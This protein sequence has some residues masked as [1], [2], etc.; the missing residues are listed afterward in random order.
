MRLIILILVTFTVIPEVCRADTIHVPTDYLTIQEAITAAA[1]G[2][3]VLVAPGTYLENINFLGKAILVK[4]SDGA[5]VTTIDGNMTGSVVT[6]ASGEGPDSILE[7]FTITNGTGTLDPQGYYC[8]GG[9]F[10]ETSSPTVTKNTIT[11]NSTSQNYV[12]GAGIYCKQASPQIIENIVTENVLPYLCYGGGIY[13]VDH[14]SPLILENVISKNITSDWGNGGGIYCK[15][16]CDVIIRDNLI[17]DNILGYDTGHGGGI[18]VY[19]DCMAEITGN[20]IT[21]NE[22]EYGG[23]IHVSYA[24]YFIIENNRIIMNFASAQGCGG[25]IYCVD[26][27]G[28][29]SRNV[30][31]NNDAQ[32]SGAGMYI[33]TLIGTVSD[34]I[35][36]ENR[37]IDTW[38]EGGGIYAIF[39]KPTI[40][41][42]IIISNHSSR[43]GGIRCSKAWPEIINNTV[44]GNKAT[45][46]GGGLYMSMSNPLIITNSIFWKNN[47]PLGPEMYLSKPSLLEISYS[48]V[49]DGI[50]G[51]HVESGCI[52][53]WGSGMIS[54]DPLFVDLYKGDLHLTFPSPCNGTGDN[55]VIT[56]LY[57]M[58]GDPRIANSTVDMGADEFYTHLYCTGDVTP[59]GNIELKF[60][61]TPNTTPVILWLG[62]G[63]MDPPM[64]VKKYGDWYLQFPILLEAGLGSI[65]GPDGILALPFNIPTGIPTPMELPL[66]ALSG[67]KLTNHSV[68]VIE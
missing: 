37:T 24:I 45:S 51:V 65:P 26:S 36:A 67:S 42:N 50:N 6:F 23:G 10:C 14:S 7:G 53:N 40:V 35:I 31:T 30:I 16:F 11:R 63:V 1:N 32:D 61:D 33:D 44:C 54:L 34:N 29:I 15:D 43:G 55:S 2:D 68:M 20:V 46:Q 5:E 66:Q 41:N 48:D 38:G 47:A 25:G 9:V 62:S 13:C 52:L 58:E 3:T 17:E 59:G 39:E 22:G 27:D 12:K 18:Y 60:I 28:V 64:H 4:G 56:E 21:G 8:G 19:E 57:D 49:E